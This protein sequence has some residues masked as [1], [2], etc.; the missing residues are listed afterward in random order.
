[1]DE[2]NVHASCVAIGSHGVLLLG[3]TGS[4]KS[5]LA[6]RLIEQGA[7]LVADDRTILFVENG[8]LK[9]R[10]P[11][12]ITGLLEVRG[13]GIVKF[14][15]RKTVGV[16]LAV[17]L[18]REGARLPIPRLFLPPQPLKPKYP[19]AEILL[20]ARYASAPAK[21][22]AALAAF[23]KGLFRETSISK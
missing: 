20:N 14:R 6:L 21:V 19:V 7:V 23:T 16:A 4:G 1:M 2:A 10:A 9:A 17:R 8:M 3:K 13:V 18:G 5:D 22:R 15:C 12:T 11:S